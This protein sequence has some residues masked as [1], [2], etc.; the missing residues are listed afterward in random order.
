MGSL[1]VTDYWG[2]DGNRVFLQPPNG[3]ID[4]FLHCSPSYLVT[5][6]RTMG[7]THPGIEK[8]EVILDLCGGGNCR[9]RVVRA[10][11]LVD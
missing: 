1:S 9:T 7:L 8:S 5:A 6:F 3:I 10:L 4:Y 2:P 11:F